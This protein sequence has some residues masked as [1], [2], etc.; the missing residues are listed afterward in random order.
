M[1]PGFIAHMLIEIREEKSKIEANFLSGVMELVD[2]IFVIKF[3][4]FILIDM[5]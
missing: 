5:F 1:K 3:V 2:K 4:V